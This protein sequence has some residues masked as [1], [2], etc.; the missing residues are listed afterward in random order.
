VSR[1]RV[2]V[3][4]LALLIAGAAAA[5]DRRGIGGKISKGAKAASAGRTAHQLAKLIAEKFTPEDEYYVGRAVAAR[6]LARYPP[7]GD[8]EAVAYLN[9]VGQTLVLA[10]PKP[11][12]YNGY[13]FIL[14]DS[15]EINAFA[16]PGAFV[17]LTR[18][19]LRCAAD[20][21]ELAAILAHELA[22]LQ[23]Q[24]GRRAIQEKRWKKFLAVAGTGAAA[25]L[26]GGVLGDLINVLGPMTDDLFV[27]LA[28]RG[29]DKELELKADL[30]AVTLL[31]DAGYDPYALKRVLER[32]A[33]R[34]DPKAGGFARTH[35]KPEQ[36][37]KRLRPRLAGAVPVAVPE[38]R[39]ERFAQALRAALED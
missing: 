30:A 7:S 36:R 33:E 4:V 20:E 18:G 39:R 37:I 28:T 14:L 24:H 1:R 35:P 15:D 23:Q 31:A 13:R 9:R 5:Q 29:Y 2:A 19:M 22:H 21:D 26:S 16:A 25:S 34:L 11:V 32:M 6:L 10:S 38:V 27:T 8:A 17:L 12:T 3:V